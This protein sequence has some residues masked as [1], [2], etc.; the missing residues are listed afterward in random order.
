MIDF[1]SG[2]L[3]RTVC[4]RQKRLEVNTGRMEEDLSAIILTIQRIAFRGITTDF[5]IQLSV[6]L[7]QLS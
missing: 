7:V 2:K 3:F 5:S 6:T 4:M 1:A